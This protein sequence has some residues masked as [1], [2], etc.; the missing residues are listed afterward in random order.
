[1]QNLGGI[2][3]WPS[4]YG[5]HLDWNEFAQL[6]RQTFIPPM[7]R[8]RKMREFLKLL[9]EGKT[10]SAYMI[11]FH[12]LE[13]YYPRLFGLE[14]ERVRICLEH[15]GRFEDQGNGWSNTIADAIDVT[16]RVDEDFSH[17]H[18]VY[19]RKRLLTLHTKFKKALSVFKG[20]Q[21]PSH[22]SPQMVR[23]PPSQYHPL[24]QF[25]LAS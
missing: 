25:L 16:T 8:R 2:H 7:P 5:M 12:H 10:L 17:S 6:F 19:R 13:W 1:M 9:Q 11:W 23:Y 14:A 18:E 21:K 24:P 4:G 20:P 15:R 3:S 22:K